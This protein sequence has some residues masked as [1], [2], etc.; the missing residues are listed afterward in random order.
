MLNFNLKLKK[1][2]EVFLSKKDP[3]KVFLF[4]KGRVAEYGI[5]KALG[6]GQGD[7]VIVSGFTCVSV[8]N[9]ILYLGAK[10]IYADINPRT[11]N[12]DVSTI[13]GLISKDTKLIIAQNTFGLP[14]ELESLEIL[15]KEYG[16]KVIEDSAHGFGGQYK[17]D[18]NGTYFDSSFFS[19]QWS[20]PLSTGIGGIAI[21][22]D[23]EVIAVLEE[24]EKDCQPPSLIDKLEIFSMWIAYMFLLNTRTFW[25]FFTLYIKLQNFKIGVDKKSDQEYEKPVFFKEFLQS[26]SSIQSLIGLFE[27]SRYN[28]TL[29]HRKDIASRYDKILKKL[30]KK[31]VYVPK[32]SDHTYLKYCIRVKCNRDFIELAKKENI[33]MNRWPYSPLTPVEHNLENWFYQLGQCKESELATRQI[34]NLP[35]HRKVN[36]NYLSRLEEFLKKHQELIL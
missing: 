11:F 9:P 28:K 10:P 20:K 6:I 36:K 27:L 24:F 16:I 19:T 31:P 18:L 17:D 7:E 21:S 35:T 23:P 15:A 30:G 34:I 32:E 14:M 5:L 2:L 1:Q 33:E 4:S 8:I 26:F 3:F 22:R 13:E 12:V 25:F 29:A